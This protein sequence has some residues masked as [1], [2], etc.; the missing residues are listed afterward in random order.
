[1]HSLKSFLPLCILM[2]NSFCKHLHNNPPRDQNRYLQNSTSRLGTELR[3]S[4]KLFLFNTNTS[5]SS[6]MSAWTDT[7]NTSV[8]TATA[9]RTMIA[10]VIESG[11]CGYSFPPLFL[12]FYLQVLNL[13]CN[14]AELLT[15]QC[16]HQT[17]R[18]VRVRLRMR[19][20]QRQHSSCWIVSGPAASRTWKWMSG[21]SQIR[22]IGHYEV[23]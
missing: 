7:T 23:H 16:E 3:A 17:G 14:L 20:Y 13:S 19:I 2:H 15:W 8:H 21:S 10:W 1:M 6:A 22:K 9:S 18:G 11:E 4:W 12:I 5:S